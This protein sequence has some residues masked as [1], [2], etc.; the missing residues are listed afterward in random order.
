MSTRIKTL[1]SFFLFFSVHN[2]FALE[3]TS[4]EVEAYI[5]GEYNRGQYNYGE[6]SLIGA[7]ELEELIR[8]RGGVSLG[9]SAESTDINAFFNVKCS[10]FSNQ[11]LSPLGF[12]LS[13]I[14]NGLPDYDVHAHSVFPFISYGNERAGL[15]FGLSL[16][17][18]SFF[19]EDPQFEPVLA[20]NVFFNFIY[21]ESFIMGASIG[22]F[23]DFDARN[24]GAWTL[25]V[26][27]VVILNKNWSIINE[28]ELRQSG[29]DGLTAT[30][31]GLSWRGGVRFSW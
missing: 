12:S 22:T 8:F 16:R 2:I 10:P 15:S 17:F 21:T 29:G 11:W 19:G 25:C 13:Y 20:F 24:M 7:I 14:Y 23:N 26:N 27:A 18:T 28:V 6:G 9:G 1:I 31:Y 5:K 3:I 30:F 4:T